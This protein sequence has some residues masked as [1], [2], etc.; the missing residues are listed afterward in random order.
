MSFCWKSMQN[1]SPLFLFLFWEEVWDVSREVI[2]L[3][4]VGLLFL[5]YDIL[6]FFPTMD[7]LSKYCCQYKS[8]IFS[9]YVCE[10]AYTHV[11]VCMCMWIW[12][13]TCVYSCVCVQMCEDQR[14]GD[15]L[16]HY[17][18]YHL[19]LSLNECGPY[20]LGKTS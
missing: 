20:Q 6:T 16:N 11:C 9:V 12:V 4:S 3:W 10:C 13:C 15:F 7:S 2:S 18:I 8:V 1:D 19:S 5:Y 14:L 17:H